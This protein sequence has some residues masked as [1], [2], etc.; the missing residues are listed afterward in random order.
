MKSCSQCGTTVES[1]QIRCSTCH[2]I[3]DT[4]FE[5]RVNICYGIFSVPPETLKRDTFIEKVRLLYPRLETVARN[6]QTRNYREISGNGI[7]SA[8]LKYLLG[9]IGMLEHEDNRPLLPSV[10]VNSANGTPGDGYY[11]LVER[12]DSLPDDIS[13]WDTKTQR[14]WWDERLTEVYSYWGE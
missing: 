13:T 7:F 9:T 10:I 8:W 11:R 4:R 6:N 14:A 5:Q 2:A 12:L 3:F 1:D